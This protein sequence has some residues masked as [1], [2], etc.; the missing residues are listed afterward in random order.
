[1][2]KDRYKTPTLD[3]DQRKTCNK[4]IQRN[5]KQRRAGRTDKFHIFSLIKNQ[6]EQ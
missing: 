5:P 1:M 2:P 6:K 4:V 3:V